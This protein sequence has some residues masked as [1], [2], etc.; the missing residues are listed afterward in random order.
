MNFLNGD[1]GLRVGDWT[2][3]QSQIPIKKFIFKFLYYYILIKFKLFNI[4]LNNQNKL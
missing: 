1:W 3:H 4:N 2:K